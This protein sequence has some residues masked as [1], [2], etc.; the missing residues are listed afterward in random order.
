MALT[1]TRGKLKQHDDYKRKI[2]TSSEFAKQ[3]I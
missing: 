2:T 3:R 1:N